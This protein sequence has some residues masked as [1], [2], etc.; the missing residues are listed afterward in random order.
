MSGGLA[1]IGVAAGVT[2]AVGALGAVGVV[3]LTRRRTF[4]AAV[5]APVVVVASLVAGVVVGARVML[6]TPEDFRAVMAALAAAL[7]AAVAV[8]LILARRL[9]AATRATARARAERER[10]LRVEASRREMV[11]RISHD[12]RTPLAG[13]RAMTEA[14]EDGVAADPGAYLARLKA[15]VLRMSGMVD[16]L[17]TLSRLRSPVLA[18]RLERVAL[19]D[20]ASDA[21]AQAMP[22]AERA[23]VMLSGSSD[24]PTPVR[25]DAREV[26]RAVANLLA[27]AIIATPAGGSVHVSVAAG[28]DHAVLE[29][30]DGCG[31]ITA[32]HVAHVFEDGWRGD[33]AR[34]PGGAG[35]GLAIV[36][37]VA[38][39]HGG[40]V[41]V[42]NG[43]PGCVFALRLP[44][45]PTG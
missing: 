37:G 21:V 10:D 6:L 43:G 17:L 34:S 26:G 41:S 18:L 32:E 42:R 15:E 4:A 13:M 14:L 35:L 3:A 28:G 22:V 40:S 23:G 2:A 5:A 20:V 38:D 9:D 16:D 33:P 36:R 29:V 44:L 7:P 30:A 31:G 45:A 1:S 11:A 24:G 19:A 27:N 8:G 39:A 25:V 12:L